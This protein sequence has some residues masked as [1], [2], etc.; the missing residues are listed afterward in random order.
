MAVEGIMGPYYWKRRTHMRNKEITTPRDLLGVGYLSWYACNLIFVGFFSVWWQRGE[1][2]LVSGQDQELAVTVGE[3]HW[4]T[5]LRRFSMRRLRLFSRIKYWIYL[6]ILRPRL[7]SYLKTNRFWDYCFSSFHSC[8]SCRC[9]TGSGFSVSG[10]RQ[11]EALD[12][13]CILGPDCGHEVEIWCWG[14]LFHL[15]LPYIPEGQVH[16]EPP[17][18]RSEGLVETCYMIVFCLAEG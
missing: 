13:C 12:F 3:L 11:Y 17:E 4:M 18:V 7:W 6:V 9:W 10:L 16:S 14:M 1:L 5:G 2:R 15:L 8:C